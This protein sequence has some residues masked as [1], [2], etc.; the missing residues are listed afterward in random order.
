[1]NKDFR[2]YLK[3]SLN[4]LIAVGL[5]LLIVLLLPKV[6]W[7]F[8]PFL[9]GWIIASIANPLVSFLEKKLRIRRKAMSVLVI[10]L[11]IAAVGG[12]LYFLISKLVEQGV[13]LVHN[14][15]T[16]WKTFEEELTGV[17][18]KWDVFYKR[19]PVSF[20][21]T[22]SELYSNL[23]TYIGDFV[24]KISSPAMSAMG[25]FVKSIPN[26]II[27]TIMCLISSYYF[28]SEREDVYHFFRTH[29][30][31]S[32]QQKW[33]VGY[34]SMKR[35]VGGYFLAQLR[36]ELWIYVLLVIGLMI[37][38]VD[39]VLLIAL[40]IALLDFLP[41]FGTGT[42][43]LPWALIRLLSGN[44]RMAVGLVIIW[45]VGQLVRQLIQPKFIG[46]TVGVKPLPTLFLLYIGYRFAGVLGMII[47]VPIGMI[48]MNLNEAGA[49]DTTR[50]SLRLLVKK[51]NDFR[52]LSKE[53]LDCIREDEVKEDSDADSDDQMSFSDES[54][55]DIE[56]INDN[57]Y[58]DIKRELTQRLR[59][60]KEEK[61]GRDEKKSK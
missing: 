21:E 38:G 55:D 14:L 57:R 32:I 50:N 2:Q 36:I 11:V 58:N 22:L 52:K 12:A 4:L 10:V 7:F 42:V 56:W 1:M 47:A 53:D 27:C 18:D 5:L 59:Q 60:I 6:I 44:Y 24:D 13:E 19:L 51:V 33:I 31:L 39:Y 15:P 8:I 16:M 28:V 46:D 49:F 26:V 9:I 3:I 37:L 20:Q 54:V 25:N 34:R 30:P 17:G 45:G 29:T 41:V 48:V 40:L 35:S 61:E 43:L 23:S